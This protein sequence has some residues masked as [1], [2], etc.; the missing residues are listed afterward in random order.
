M[1]TGDPPFRHAYIGSVIDQVEV[2]VPKSE[3]SA[4]GPWLERLVMGGGAAP[5][6]VPS[7]VRKWRARKHLVLWLGS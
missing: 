6:G 7:F 5:S 1:L 3:S 2:D 4:E